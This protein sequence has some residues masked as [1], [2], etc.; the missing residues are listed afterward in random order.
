MGKYQAYGEW[1]NDPLNFFVNCGCNLGPCSHQYS[2]EILVCDREYVSLACQSEPVYVLWTDVKSIGILV[3]GECA[4]WR[5]RNY[6]GGISIA[7]LY[8]FMGFRYQPDYFCYEQI[9]F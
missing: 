8:E 3:C 7:D 6:G 9:T 5:K 4:M 1:L 2:G